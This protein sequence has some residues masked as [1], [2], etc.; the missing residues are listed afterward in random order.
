M[1]ECGRALHVSTC[2]TALVVLLLASSRLSCAQF[3]LPPVWQ[4][5]AASPTAAVL[6][7][8]DD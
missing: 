7:A 6:L 5:C 1:G 8:F 4:K 2:A 3:T